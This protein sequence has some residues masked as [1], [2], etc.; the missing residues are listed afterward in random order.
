MFYIS[1]SAPVDLC[2]PVLYSHLYV[3]CTSPV[4]QT[5]TDLPAG[6]RPTFPLEHLNLTRVWLR[7]ARRTQEAAI[8]TV[9]ITSGSREVFLYAF[10]IKAAEVKKAWHFI[11]VVEQ[12]RG[13]FGGWYYSMRFSNTRHHGLLWFESSHSRNTIYLVILSHKY[14]FF[15][16]PKCVCIT[17][18][19]DSL[20]TVTN[21]KGHQCLKHHVDKSIYQF[22]FNSSDGF[23]LVQYYIIGILLNQ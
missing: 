11:A 18:L 19:K 14:I 2:D 9:Y 23:I 3:T 22:E 10:R 12:C 1:C 21:K 13:I 8:L 15:H 4:R 6:I 7:T 5:Q 20:K 17:S 16:L